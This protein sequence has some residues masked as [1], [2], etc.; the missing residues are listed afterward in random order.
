[1]ISLWHVFILTSFGLIHSYASPSRIVIVRGYKEACTYGIDKIRN[2]FNA[3]NITWDHD[4][5]RQAE[6]WAKQ[7]LINKNIHHSGTIQG[8]NIFY[9]YHLNNQASLVEKLS[10]SQPL[11]YWYNVV[12]NDKISNKGTLVKMIGERCK[13]FGIGVAYDSKMVIFVARFDVNIPNDTWQS[14]H[15]RKERWRIPDRSRL[16]S[17]AGTLVYKC[18]YKY[19]DFK[20]NGS[21]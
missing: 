15:V 7:L 6:D 11:W 19:Q 10:C 8:E 18:Y 9:T 1:M 4:L 16:K 13:K 21:C 12:S 17:S 14:Y 2:A 3:G 5:A 20:G